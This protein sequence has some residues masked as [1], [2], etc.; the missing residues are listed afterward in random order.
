MTANFDWLYKSRTPYWELDPIRQPG[1]RYAA[2]RQIKNRFGEF[3][4]KYTLDEV[5]VRVPDI[6]PSTLR[7]FE[8]GVDLSSAFVADV[9]PKLIADLGITQEMFNTAEKI[10][11]KDHKASDNT[12]GSVAIEV[13][14]PNKIE[15]VKMVPKTPTPPSNDDK[16][17]TLMNHTLSS[18]VVVIK[19]GILHVYDDCAEVMKKVPSAYWVAPADDI[20][21]G[22]KI[23]P[24]STVIKR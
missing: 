3:A 16:C 6:K 24:R 21:G 23:V 17:I 11:A 10:T 7:T 13:A 8:S 22:L 14:T 18:F 20:G 2:F 15:K 5:C 19:D 4:G 1:K 9:L 12:T